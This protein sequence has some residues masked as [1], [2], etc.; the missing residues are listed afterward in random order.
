M[1]T[2][3]A[4]PRAVLEFDAFS[5]SVSIP[6]FVISETETHYSVELLEDCRFPGYSKQYR[7]GNTVSVPKWTVKTNMP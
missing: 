4:K 7:C 6:V 3:T 2:P 1:E 5:G